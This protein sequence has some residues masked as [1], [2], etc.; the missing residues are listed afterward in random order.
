MKF[1]LL[2]FLI[3]L[4]AIGQTVYKT[5]SGKKYH[6]ADCHMI[7]NKSAALDV[8]KAVEIGLEPC[9]MCSPPTITAQKQTLK[10]S[11]AAGE[12]TVSTQCLGTT[13]KGSRC[14][15]KTKIGNGY[16]FQ[17]QPD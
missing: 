3:S 11:G 2:L 4:S 8:S 13:K 6:R 9:K 15:H 7:K 12:K 17:H 10:I 5:P 16:C 14:K 1:A